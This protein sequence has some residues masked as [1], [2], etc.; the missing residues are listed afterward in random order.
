M[1]SNDT[2]DA[3]GDGQTIADGDCDDRPTFGV[4]IKK[5]ATEICGDGL[6]NDCNGKADDGCLPWDQGQNYP[7]ESGSVDANSNEGFINFRGA[8][9]KDGLLRA[10]PSVFSVSIEITR[11]IMFDLNLSNVFVEA[12]VKMGTNG[13]EIEDGLL[14]GVLSARVVDL[15]PNFIADFGFGSKDD[16]LLDTLLGP[17]GQVLA[18]PKDVQGNRIPDIDVDGDGIEKFLDTDLDGDKGA[19]RVDTCIDGDGTVIKNEYDANGKVTKKCT[20]ALD[21]NG[22][23]RFVDGWSITL[24]FSGLPSQIKGTV[25]T[26]P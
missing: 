12:K 25:S 19:F 14:G 15:A 18:L 7:I 17:A 13:L 6:D 1:P 3:D 10:G 21:A 26:G 23:P 8:T 22:K 16:S 2:T 4:T 20:Q 24:K 9:I 11:G 5:G